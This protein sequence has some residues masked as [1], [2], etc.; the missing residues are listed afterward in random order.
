[1]TGKNFAQFNVRKALA[2]NGV[3]EKNLRSAKSV[4]LFLNRLSLI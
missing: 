1:M 3:A 2:A 4:V